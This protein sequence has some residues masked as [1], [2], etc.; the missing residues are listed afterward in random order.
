MTTYAIIPA[1]KGSKRLPRKNMLPL[2]G[3]PLVQWTIDAALDSREVD[4]VVVSTDWGVVG[5]V[6]TDLGAD[7][8]AR[9]AWLAGDKA[10]SEAV[11][12]HAI[13]C[14]SQI[15]HQLH[16]TPSD[17][18]LLLQPTSPTR[19]GADIDAFLEEARGHQR[20]FTTSVAH[21]HDKRVRKPNGAIYGFTVDAFYR[22]GLYLDALPVHQAHIDID[23][24]T[25]LDRA[26]EHLGKAA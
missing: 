16:P 14:M 1:R 15:D 2:A 4:R 19:S 6:A 5:R 18:I 21:W 12:F 8:L 25:D 20:A 24:L 13:A 11:I 23:D 9:P 7:V 3:K 10:S 22:G 26:E 17:R